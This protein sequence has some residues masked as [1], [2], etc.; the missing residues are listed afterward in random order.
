MNENQYFLTVVTIADRPQQES[1]LGVGGMQ[2]FQPF[3]QRPSRET[4]ANDICPYTLFL[5]FTAD[6]IGKNE[7]FVR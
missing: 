4:S 5:L 1:G 6:I 2:L 7:V 3:S